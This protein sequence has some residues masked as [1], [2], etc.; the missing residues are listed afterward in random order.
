[1]PDKT[2]STTE[3]TEDLA[4]LQERVRAL[5]ERDR[6]NALIRQAVEQ[7]VHGIVI[8][9]AHGVITYANRT[10]IRMHG[11]GDNEIIGKS[12]REVHGETEWQEHGKAFALQAIKKGSHAGELMHL[13][14]DGTHFPAW[15]LVTRLAGGNGEIRG[16][17]ATV[18]DITEQK[19]AE[20][21][22][23]ESEARFR[24]QFKHVP[25]PTYIWTKTETDFQLTDF[26]DAAFAITNGGI[27]GYV[28]RTLT[29]MYPQRPEIHADM[30]ECFRLQEIITREMPYRFETTGEDKILKVR[31][32]Y[33]PPDMVLVHTEDVTSRRMAEASLRESEQ[34][35]HEAQRL[36]LTGSWQ[37]DIENEEF[38]LSPMMRDIQGLD[39]TTI[40]LQE[41]FDVVHPDDRK[42]VDAAYSE[43]V[44]GG[45]K[46]LEY[47]ILRPNGEVRR[48]NSPGAR[49]I[50]DE[51]GK[52]IR[53]VGVSQDITD[54]KKAEQAL[55]ESEERFRQLAENIKDVFWLLDW[56]EQ[57]II[58]A[59][60]AYETVWG[61]SLSQLRDDPLDWIDAIHPDDR[62]RAQDAYFPAAVTS[63]NEVYRV[64]RPDGSLRWIHH[65][66]FPIEDAEGRV[67]RMAGIAEDITDQK[68]AED[69][70][71]QS[72]ERYRTLYDNNPSMYFTVDAKGI[73]KDVNE[74]G[75]EQLG[76][77]VAELVGRPVLDI[78]HPDD[79]NEVHG[80]M[81]SCLQTPGRI[82][83]WEYR[84]VC[85][86]GRVIHVEEAARAVQAPGGERVVLVV[87]EDITERKRVE[88][89][90]LDSE[91]RFRTLTS[92]APVGIFQTDAQGDCLFVNEKWC[93]FAGITQE[94]ARGSHWPDA[95]LPADQERVSAEWRAALEAG[96]EFASEFRF[97]TA[98]GNV[99]WLFAVALAMHDE[100][101]T[102]TG[103]LGTITDITKL[104][105]AEDALRESEERFRFL[106]ESNPSMYFTL[107]LDGRVLSVNQYGAEQLGY[108][109]DELVGASV[110]DVFHPDDRE[111]VREQL[112]TCGKRPREIARWE[113]RK[114]RKDGKTIWVHEAAR[115][116]RGPN[117]ET[118]I[119]VVCEDITDRRGDV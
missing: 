64:I 16:F 5:E 65:R 4:A 76:Y 55:R 8:S 101:G 39:R 72:E 104:K 115:A 11:Y 62:E 10:Y 78:F 94:Q 102:I 25:V 99:S 93:E 87:C 9:N 34:L 20:A 110:F 32:A 119:L 51:N 79:R 77:T 75:A 48:L 106:Y 57:K 29:S 37:L 43:A 118:V 42:R 111:S 88:A 68:L 59:S 74:F 35:L 69:A 73:V 108:V 53:I 91:R 21:S 44:A 86:D 30:L 23:R 117:G 67:Y 40:S 24:A 96:Q 33:I 97:S 28:G 81:V 18:R 103:Y 56:T 45:P 47:R 83:H 98:Q 13:R 61:R 26:N 92:L 41:A 3:P 114:V 116:V 89:A 71:R 50:R 85:K 95:L 90:L 1:M 2:H 6:E 66:G 107:D 109:P 112:A 17:M 82:A 100:H 15:V 31:Y 19:K 38:H 7:S 80:Q 63:Y 60:P 54:R 84:K 14:K 113:Y 52:P 27:A 12:V 49:L 105:Q 58:Y 22:L 70:L 46:P 36:S